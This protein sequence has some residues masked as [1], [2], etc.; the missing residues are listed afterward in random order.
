MGIKISNV[1]T[2]RLTQKVYHP[3][4][5]PGIFEKRSRFRVSTIC[6]GCVERVK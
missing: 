2:L 1:S 3:C 4:P 5:R 6:D